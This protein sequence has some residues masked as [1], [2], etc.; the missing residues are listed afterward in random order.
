MI[1]LEEVKKYIA[2]DTKYDDDLINKLIEQAQIY[3]DSCVGTG[4]QKYDDKVKLSNL[5][6]KKIIGDLYNN[7][8]LYLDNKKGGYDRISNTILD[9]LANCGDSNE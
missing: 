5:L 4:Y 8:D 7:R 9:I 1:T 6:L 3:I 2:V